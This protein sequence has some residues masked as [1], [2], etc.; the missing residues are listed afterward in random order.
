MERSEAV[1]AC[2]AQHKHASTT[3]LL[4]TSMYLLCSVPTILYLISVIY[5]QLELGFYSSDGG[6]TFNEFRRTRTI[7][8]F[9]GTSSLN[10]YWFILGLLLPIVVNSTLNPAIYCWRM[11]AFR[12]FILRQDGAVGPDT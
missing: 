3:V 5:Q 9:A 7:K 8:N 11:H 10:Y 2:A 1:H 12:R 6:I 4:F